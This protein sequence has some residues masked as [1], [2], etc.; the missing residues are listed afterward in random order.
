MVDLW[1]DQGTL[2]VALLTDMTTGWDALTTEVTGTGYVREELLG[3]SLG[4]ASGH[5][6]IARKLEGTYL[7]FDNT[8]ATDWEPI[9]HM[10]ILAPFGASVLAVAALPEPITVTPDAPLVFVPGTVSFEVVTAP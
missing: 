3:S 4:S 5:D 9:T 2:Q 8:G 7:L 6:P 1:A 10:A